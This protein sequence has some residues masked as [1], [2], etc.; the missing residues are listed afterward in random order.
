LPTPDE[1]RQGLA[2][3]RIQVEGTRTADMALHDV[4]LD[5]GLTMGHSTYDTI[6]VAFAIATGA[7]AVVALDGPFVRDIR[8]HPN[9]ILAN[10]V[11][12]LGEWAAKR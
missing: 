7:R 4:A 3:L 2:L 1:A 8:K 11:I 10:K 6:Y 9:P 12:S 5:I